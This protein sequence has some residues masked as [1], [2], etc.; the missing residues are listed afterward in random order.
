MDLAAQ[1][2]WSQ[3][4]ANL[5]LGIVAESSA[6][7]Q[8]ASS[9]F[10]DVACQRYDEL[11]APTTAGACGFNNTDA[12]SGTHVTKE[13]ELLNSLSE[14]HATLTSLGEWAHEC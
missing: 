14:C 1:D 10:R 6:E 11:F 13:L 2:R 8:A 7:P 4:R 12:L 9:Y 5:Y 3:A